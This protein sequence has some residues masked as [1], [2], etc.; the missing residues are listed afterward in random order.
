M[1]SAFRDVTPSGDKSL[2]IGR[3]QPTP[4]DE[5]LPLVYDELRRLAVSRLS[6]ERVGHTLQATELVHEAYLRLLGPSGEAQSWEHRGH[7]FAAAAEAMRR[8]LIENARK[9]HLHKAWAGSGSYF[10]RRDHPCCPRASR[11]RSR[12]PGIGRSVTRLEVICPRRAAV[13][14]LRYFAGLTIPQAAEAL[15]IARSTADDDWAYAKSWLRVELADQ[16]AQ[17]V[18][19]T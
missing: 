1:N 6:D 13:V 4:A 8:I 2:L 10:C 5:L 12:S 3:E 18:G 19:I 9:K 11:G 14:K 17:S 15:G 7:F 16:A